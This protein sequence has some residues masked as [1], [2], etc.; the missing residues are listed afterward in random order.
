MPISHCC[1]NIHWLHW[2]ADARLHWL[3]IWPVVPLPVV[4][5]LSHLHETHAPLGDIICV[6]QDERAWS[7]GIRS[8][9]W[10]VPVNH[11]TGADPSFAG[12]GQLDNV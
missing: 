5:D 2:L 8:T 4:H 3:P 11:L 9:Q 1:T 6:G 7:L 10:Y 12:R